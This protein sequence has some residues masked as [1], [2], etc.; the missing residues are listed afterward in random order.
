MKQERPSALCFKGGRHLRTC[1]MA[2]GDSENVQPQKN[3]AGKTVCI[4][5]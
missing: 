3:E 2:A 5:L 4:V 1:M